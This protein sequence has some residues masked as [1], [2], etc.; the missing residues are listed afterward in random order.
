MQSPTP[1]S[2]DGGDATRELEE[3]DEEMPQG[4]DGEEQTEAEQREE[5]LLEIGHA[6]TA[7]PSERDVEKL[8]A[9]GIGRRR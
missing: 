1:V 3:D 7:L 4:A 2:P 6:G 9:G 8:P 5:F